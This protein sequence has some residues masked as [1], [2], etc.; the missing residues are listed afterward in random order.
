MLEVC[1]IKVNKSPGATLPPF[2]IVD[3]VASEVAHVVGGFYDR[4]RKEMYPANT[5]GLWDEDECEA[6][7]SLVLTEIAL[8]GYP[9]D[10]VF[11]RI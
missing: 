4:T 5:I 8:T 1:A 9:A 11:E 7:E 10:V 2:Q 3:E 6:I